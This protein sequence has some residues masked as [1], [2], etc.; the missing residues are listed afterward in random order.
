MVPVENGLL[1]Q[2]LCCHMHRI[3]PDEEGR[4]IRCQKYHTTPAI[5]GL[6]KSLQVLTS[7]NC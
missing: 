7:G 1:H 3:Q 4:L 2:V 6:R 5:A